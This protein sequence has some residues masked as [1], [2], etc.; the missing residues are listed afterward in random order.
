MEELFVSLD[1][2]CSPSLLT[3]GEEVD[4]NAPRTKA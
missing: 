1:P 4:L 2:M 3:G